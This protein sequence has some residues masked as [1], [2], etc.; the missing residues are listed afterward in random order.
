M[1]VDAVLEIERSGER[2]ERKWRSDKSARGIGENLPERCFKREGVTR[3]EGS[4]EVNFVICG[5]RRRSD[6]EEAV[7]RR[8]A[9]GSKRF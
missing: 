9:S 1:H 8:I 6:G 5:G 2:G 4:G 3:S 7:A